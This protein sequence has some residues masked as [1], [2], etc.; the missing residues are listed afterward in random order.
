MEG[1]ARPS[2]K[3]PN[4]PPAT[5][6]A[7]QFFDFAVGFLELTT[8]SVFG[9]LIQFPQD[10]PDVVSYRS[11]HGFCLLKPLWPYHDRNTRSIPEACA[12]E[13]DPN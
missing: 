4:F 2:V 12:M 7:A 1:K 3:R 5:H 13:G 8:G 11:G 10:G 9:R 6:L